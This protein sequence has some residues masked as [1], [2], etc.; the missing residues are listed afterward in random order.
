MACLQIEWVKKVRDEDVRQRLID[1]LLSESSGISDLNRM[2][3]LTI[4]LEL[5][6][7]RR[8]TLPLDAKSGISTLSAAKIIHVSE[9]IIALVDTSRLAITLSTK[10]PGGADTEDEARTKLDAAKS[11]DMLVSALMSKCRALAFQVS[12]DRP[13]AALAD[14]ESA[15]VQLAKW[16]DNGSDLALDIEY[17]LAAVIPLHMGKQEYAHALVALSRWTEK[18]P[19]T[20]TNAADWNT[21]SALQIRLLDKLGWPLWVDNFKNRLAEE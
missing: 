16:S 20:H 2:R 8:R 21:V 9:R 4:Q 18:A 17:L 15:V 5:L 1:E 10:L 7:A 11:R 6:D 3:V 12:A 14:Y 19:M 13:A